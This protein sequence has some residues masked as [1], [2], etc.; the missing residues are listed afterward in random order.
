MNIFKLVIVQNLHNFPKFY[1]IQLIFFSF[2]KFIHIHK[3]D[4]NNLNIT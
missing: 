1:E 2:M 3:F 4:V